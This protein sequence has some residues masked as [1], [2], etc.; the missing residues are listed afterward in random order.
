MKIQSPAKSRAFESLVVYRRF[1]AKGEDLPTL[2]KP[3]IDVGIVPPIGSPI[4]AGWI[5]VLE[6]HATWTIREQ[7]VHKAHRKP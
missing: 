4:E 2:L 5:V 6:E 3:R 1:G 7:G